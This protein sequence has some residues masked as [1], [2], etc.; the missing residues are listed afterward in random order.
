MINQPPILATKVFDYL[1][2]LTIDSVLN[3]GLAML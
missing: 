2:N 3:F 1:I